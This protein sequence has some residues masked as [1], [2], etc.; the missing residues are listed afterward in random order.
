MMPRFTITSKRTGLRT[1]PFGL[2]KPSH[3]FGR[4]KATRTIYRGQ[5]LT[6][7]KHTLAN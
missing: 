4:L 7:P 6:L 3:P 1:I 5:P 2:S